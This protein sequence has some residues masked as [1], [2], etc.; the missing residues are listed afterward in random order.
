[1]SMGI[2]VCYSSGVGDAYA[3]DLLYELEALQSLDEQNM[4]A[5][6]S[7]IVIEDEPEMYPASEVLA[8]LEKAK[9]AFNNS[10]APT[11]IN[12]EAVMSDLDDL[13]ADVQ[14]A[15]EKGQKVGLVGC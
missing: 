2:Q 15:V 10:G 5:I 11:L 1:M 4:C 6:A 3:Q 14:K 9:A 12:K 8:E 7:M 13:M